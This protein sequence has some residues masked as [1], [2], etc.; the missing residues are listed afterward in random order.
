MTRWVVWTGPELAIGPILRSVIC[1]GITCRARAILFSLDPPGG[2]IPLP[3]QT[4]NFFLAL[5][6]GLH[7]SLLTVHNRGFSR[8]CRGD[9]RRWLPEIFYEHKI[10]PFL[11]DL[12]IE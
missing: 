2:L 12:R 3:L 4:S 8:A 7:T 11:V 9:A 6:K 5:L 10:A 1:R